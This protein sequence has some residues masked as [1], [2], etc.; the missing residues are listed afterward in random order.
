MLIIY[1]YCGATFLSRWNRSENGRHVHCANVVNN[2][3]FLL[4]LTQ[5]LYIHVNLRTLKFDGIRSR[6]TSLLW[7]YCGATFLSR[8]NR[9]EN[10]RHVHGANAINND[11]FSLK[12]TSKL[13]LHVYLP[14]LQFDGI[15]SRGTSLLW[16]YCGATFCCEE[17]APKMDDKYM[18]LTPSITICSHWNLHRSCIYMCAYPHYSLTEFKAEEHH[19]SE[20]IVV[21]LFVAKQLLR[22]WMTRTWY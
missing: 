20:Y 18:V 7:T 8:R 5:K 16:I 6:G 3:R 10:G 19:F 13:Y 21:P 12:L 22:K 11:L 1:L 17:I 4:K 14:T 9:S 15:W 2:G